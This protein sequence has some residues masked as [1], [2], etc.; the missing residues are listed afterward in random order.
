[1]EGGTR[2]QK[3]QL[4]ELEQTLSI[5][6]REASLRLLQDSYD[7]SGMRINRSRT[8]LQEPQ[9]IRRLLSREM[10]AQG[11]CCGDRYEKATDDSTGNLVCLQMSELRSQVITSRI[12]WRL[13]VSTNRAITLEGNLAVLSA[14]I[15]SFLLK[16]QKGC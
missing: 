10:K 4:W 3:I 9:K 1:M 14:R 7:P 16:R 15:M 11:G 6:R 2:W 12:R 5:R 8:P 13:P